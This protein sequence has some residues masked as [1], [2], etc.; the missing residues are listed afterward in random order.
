MMLY[1]PTTSLN[2]NDILATESISPE[3]FYNKRTFG[4]K[5]HFK[6]ELSTSS[7]YV[8][9][10]NKIPYF[11]LIDECSSEYDEY[12]I[13]LSLDIPASKSKEFIE[14]DNNCFA[15]DK[16]IYINE[17]SCN[18]LFF[19]KEHMN[20]VV[21]K[22]TTVSEVKTLLKYE[23]QFKIMDDHK[24]A[25][26]LESTQVKLPEVSS[27]DVEISLFHDRFFN[28]I[29]GLIYGYIVEN[30]KN[31]VIKYYNDYLLGVKRIE[32]IQEI[33]TINHILN[34]FEAEYINDQ[35]RNAEKY[36]SRCLKLLKE[37]YNS[38]ISDLQFI[39]IT[40]I[41]DV[42]VNIDLFCDVQDLLVFE[43]IINILFQNPKQLRKEITSENNMVTLIELIKHQIE[44][45]LGNISIYYKDIS[46]TLERIKDSNFDITIECIK[47]IIMKNLFSFAL[48][49]DSIDELKKFIQLKNI[50]DKHIA[51]SFLGAYIGYA[52][53]SRVLTDNVFKNGNSD[54]TKAIDSILNDLMNSIKD[55]KNISLYKATRCSE[56]D[57]SLSD[58]ST[59][60]NTIECPDSSVTA[61]DEK[62]N[63]SEELDCD[64]LISSQ[65]IKRQ[66][67]IEFHKLKQY[68]NIN[69]L[70]KEKRVEL[71]NITT[72]ALEETNF[73]VELCIKHHSRPYDI[74]ILIVDKQNITDN[75][76]N[77]LNFK[78]EVQKLGITKDIYKGKYPFL[79]YFKRTQDVV[80]DLDIKEEKEL[81]NT[82]LQLKQRII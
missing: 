52:D 42:K 29:K 18:I 67:Y 61:E 59:N 78:E 11:S 74:I 12:P 75:D 5:R 62:I 58:I 1:Y 73:N 34:D 32:G 36:S 72:M 66:L 46:L 41:G 35:L 60:N 54:L 23:S 71:E 30:E 44:S 40:E 43:M 69:K 10:F 47:S 53:L 7:D 25:I 4:T 3:S 65:E 82:L 50:H 38:S 48:K 80:L 79:K 21:A 49:Y 16:T 28:N 70:I 26:K 27:D 56:A 64:T 68:K 45:N 55:I 63:A 15:T 22:S 20:N 81:L 8:I 77:F 33:Y 2:F 37:T 39:S 76:Y 24:A 19:S 13:V 6:T 57:H 9:L 17:Y 31:N 51:Y 14:F